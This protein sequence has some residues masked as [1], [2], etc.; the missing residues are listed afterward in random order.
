MVTQKPRK[1]KKTTRRKTGGEQQKGT[2]VQRSTFSHIYSCCHRQ[3]TAAAAKKWHRAVKK[4]SNT[5][6]VLVNGAG[7][8]LQFIYLVRTRQ[9][10]A[11]S[12][13]TGRGNIIKINLHSSCEIEYYAPFSMDGGVRFRI[14]ISVQ[15]TRNSARYFQNSREKENLETQERLH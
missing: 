8:Y 6:N 9:G 11:G 4:S 13:Y 15:I 7:A 1:K 12:H 2:K 10:S 5:Q 3:T 14:F